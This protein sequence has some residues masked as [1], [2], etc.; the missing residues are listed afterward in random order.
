MPPNPKTTNRRLQRL[1]AQ[2]AEVGF[3]LPGTINI[4]MNRCGKPNCACH[5]DPPKLHG[6]YITWTRKVSGKTITRRLPPNSSSATSPGS[7][8]TAGCAGSPKTSKR[9]HYKPPNTPKAGNTT[10]H[11]PH[12]LNTATDNPRPLWK[13][14]AKAVKQPPTAPKTPRKIANVK[15]SSPRFAGKRMQATSPSLGPS[16]QTP[17]IVATARCCDRVLGA[18]PRRLVEL[19]DHVAVGAHTHSAECP[20]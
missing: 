4:A 11:H 18:D 16:E 15:T 5:H 2:L 6:P 14:A 12:R 19:L 1:Q 13:S 8:T 7:T 17:N 10:P 20:S 3:A 9:S